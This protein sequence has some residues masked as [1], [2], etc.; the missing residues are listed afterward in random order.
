MFSC[1]R[2]Y[3]FSFALR[4]GRTLARRAKVLHMDTMLMKFTHLNLQTVMRTLR[5][6]PWR[7]QHPALVLLKM[8][9]LTLSRRGRVS[10]PRARPSPQLTSCR[11]ATSESSN[12]KTI[13]PKWMHCFLRPQRLHRWSPRFTA[14][15]SSLGSR[16]SRLGTSRRHWT[17]SSPSRSKQ[18]M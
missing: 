8:V 4:R 12:K 18:E 3:F 11:R 1:M 15:S 9:T 13:H 14:E 10:L 16:C 2:R 17:S 7:R 5:R 6:R